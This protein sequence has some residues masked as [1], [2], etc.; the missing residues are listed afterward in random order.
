MY[1]NSYACPVCDTFITP[2][3]SCRCI[4]G[5]CTKVFRSKDYNALLWVFNQLFT[6]VE[7]TKA[8]S[9]RNVS[10]E[11]FVVCRGFKAPKR[12]DPKFLDP[13]SVF[14]E[15]SE[16]GCSLPNPVRARTLYVD[17]AFLVPSRKISGYSILD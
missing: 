3:D 17:W 9:S 12:I 14:V 15:L 10:A 13:R 7:A 2:S 1:T 4:S 11:I 6:N 5:I 16:T 8:P